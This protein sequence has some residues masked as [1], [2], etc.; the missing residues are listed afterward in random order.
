MDLYKAFAD[1]LSVETNYV[2]IIMIML[3]FCLVI[4][5]TMSYEALYNLQPQYSLHLE[6]SFPRYLYGSLG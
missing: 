1:N 3:K 6:V 4:I 2:F 5:L